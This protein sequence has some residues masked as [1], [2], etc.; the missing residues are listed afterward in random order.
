MHKNVLAFSSFIHVNHKFNDFNKILTGSEDE[1]PD[2]LYRSQSLENVDVW[3][4][5]CS[6]INLNYKTETGQCTHLHG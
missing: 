3:V 4:I 2:K 1:D 5:M 6:Q